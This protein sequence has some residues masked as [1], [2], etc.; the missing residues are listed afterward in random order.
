MTLVIQPSDK[1]LGQVLAGSANGV[2]VLQTQQNSAISTSAGQV[3]IQTGTVLTA[4][5]VGTPGA[6][7]PYLFS[8]ATGGGDPG[9]TFLALN[10]AAS[11]SATEIYLDVVNA[12]LGNVA[13]QLAIIPVGSTV[14]VTQGSDTVTYTV[15]SVTVS[16]YVTLGVSYVGGPNIT[17]TNDGAT[18]FMVTSQPRYGAQYFDQFGVLQMQADQFG[19]HAF[20]NSSASSAGPSVYSSELLPS[21]WAPLTLASGVSPISAPAPTPSVRLDPGGVVRLKGVLANTSGSTISA[22]TTLATLPAEPLGLVPF[23]DVAATVAVGS[24]TV[25]LL[26][27]STGT[28]YIYQPLTTSEEVPLDGVSWTLD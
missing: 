11:G 13:K 10:A 6:G 27:K 22:F 8:S 17:F 23:W 3:V 18:E 28:I 19:L 1:R 26:V 21:A 15:R 24:A 14:T 5:P 20:T 25:G 7:F 4:A 2:G 9:V 12:D 16:G